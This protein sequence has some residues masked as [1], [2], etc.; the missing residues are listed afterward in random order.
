M[1]PAWFGPLSWD[2]TL[3]FTGPDR[4]GRFY[5]SEI[6]SVS[7]LTPSVFIGVF[8]FSWDVLIFFLGK[9]FRKVL[10]LQKN[11]QDSTEFPCIFR[12]FS[13][14]INILHLYDVS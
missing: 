4:V 2:F 11:G 8:K 13:S 7:S 12:L 9:F 3:P 10:D 6:L 1:P 5:R 14:V